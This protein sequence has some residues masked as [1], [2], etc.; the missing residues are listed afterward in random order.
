MTGTAGEDMGKIYIDVTEV[1][2]TELS[3]GIQRSVREFSRRLV[4]SMDRTRLI[5]HEAGTDNYHIVS[6]ERLERKAAEGTDENESGGTIKLAELEPGDIFLDLDSVWNKFEE[7]RHII[8]RVLKER[9]VRIITLVY[10]ILPI[11]HPRFFHEDTLC[12]FILY[13]SAVLEYTDLIIVNSNAVKHSLEELM[14]DREIPRKK[15]RVVPLGADFS[16]TADE[17]EEISDPVRKAAERPFLMMLGTMEPRKNHAAALDA[18]DAG[19]SRLPVNLV[20]AGR[21]GW[22]IAELTERIDNHPDL[23]KRLFRLESPS[24]AEVRY[25]YER[26]YGLIFA[27]FGEGFGLPLTEA[28][29][30]HKIV[31][32]S[33]IEVFREIGGDRC[34]YFDPERPETLVRTAAEIIADREKEERLREKTEQF[35]VTSWDEAAEQLAAAVRDAEHEDGKTT[36]MSGGSQMS[37]MRNAIRQDTEIIPEQI[38]MISARCEDLLETLPFHENFIPFLKELVLG[39][40]SKLIPEVEEAYKGRLKIT[41]LTDEELL[42]GRELPRDHQERNTLLRALAIRSGKLKDVFIMA[43]DDNRPLKTISPDYFIREGRF[44]LYYYGEDIRRWQPNIGRPTS[45]DIGQKK[46]AAFLEENGLPFRQYSSHEPQVICRRVYEEALDKYPSVPG[47]AIDEWTFYGNYAT[48]AYPDLFDAEPYTT[49]CWPG[50][51]HNWKLKVIPQEYVFENYYRLLYKEG[52][53][54]DGI[55]SE[56]S[57]KTPAE[58]LTKVQRRLAQQEKYAAGQEVERACGFIYREAYGKA[59]AWEVNMD[60]SR[61]TVPRILMGQAGFWARVPFRI[62]NRTKR[63]RLKIDGIFRGQEGEETYP[64]GGVDLEAKEMDGDHEISIRYPKTLFRG[65]LDLTFAIDDEAPVGM[66]I[67]VITI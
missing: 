41:F 39:C 29:Y 18:W 38:Y 1:L 40:P 62:I 49:M 26:A 14:K 7:R 13:L 53:I 47:S 22:N 23:G 64:F 32:A 33:D 3:S 17:K 59:P 55:S 5:R 57:E 43:D 2:R 21:T 15:I 30:Y 60:E 4:R 56:Y 35:R 25:L 24:D 9:G 11:T 36:E 48:S 46:T 67:P 28:L 20:I 51:S 8:Y 6:P 37:D 10:D 42:D 45:Y 50:E 65:T 19:L 66:S 58:N 12:H 31:L 61:I 52:H 16:R 54:F 63:E 44:R 27:S 34:L